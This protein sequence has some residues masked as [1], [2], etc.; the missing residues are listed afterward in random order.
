MAYELSCFCLIPLVV[1]DCTQYDVLC[2][3]GGLCVVRCPFY[4]LYS[5]FTFILFYLFYFTLFSIFLLLILVGLF[6]LFDFVWL[7]RSVNI[8]GVS[9][10]EGSIAHL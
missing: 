8:S 6:V 9:V 4:L 3:L 1:L 5:T 2:V 7:V 10:I